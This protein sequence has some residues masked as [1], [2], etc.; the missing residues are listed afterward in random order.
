MYLRLLPSMTKSFFYS[1][2]F[3][4][5]L[6]NMLVP[7]AGVFG[8]GWNIY[9]IFLLFLAELYFTGVIS[10]FKIIMSF[11]GLA[12]FYNGIGSKIA[13]LFLFCL[14]YS[15]I[16]FFALAVIISNYDYES[17]ISITIPPGILTVI[18]ITYMI[19]FVSG[20]VMNGKFRTT[21]PAQVAKESLGMAG[22]LVLIL[23]GIVFI[24]HRVTSAGNDTTLV[25]AVIFVRA[26]FDLI[27]NWLHFKTFA[28]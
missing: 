18:F 15:V 3:L 10:V 22:V 4:L 25:I 9:D 7:L 27:V 2:R 12:H 26:S 5:T 20:F 24:L 28:N 23:L 16:L 19:G 1:P 8:F 21:P 11:G 17:H 14:F 13:L 6:V